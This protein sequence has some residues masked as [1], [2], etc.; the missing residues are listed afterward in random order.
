MQRQKVTHQ[1]KFGLGVNALCL[2]GAGLI[3]VHAL[4]VMDEWVEGSKQQEELK[5]RNE[6]DQQLIVL[7]KKM[8]FKKTKK[9]QAEEAE[10]ESEES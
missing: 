9:E 3:F 10:D 4:K 6:L 1:F 2:A 7:L 8:L 5:K